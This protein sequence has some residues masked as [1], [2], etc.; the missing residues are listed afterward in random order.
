MI[1]VYILFFLVHILSVS[2]WTFK[3]KTFRHIETKESYAAYAYTKNMLNNDVFTCISSKSLCPSAIWKKPSR[4]FTPPQGML[5]PGSSNVGE[6]DGLNEKRDGRGP[7]R[8]SSCPCFCLQLINIKTGNKVIFYIFIFDDIHISKIP[9]S[10][11]TK[12]VPTC[13]KY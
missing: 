2:P 13:L 4:S 3:Y 9:D 11:A 1:Y 10:T 6:L 8:K 5:V 12:E 7:C